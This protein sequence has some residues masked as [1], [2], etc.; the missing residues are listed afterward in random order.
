MSV[1]TITAVDKSLAWVDCL[2]ANLILY[3]DYFNPKYSSIYEFGLIAVQTILKAGLP[4][5][6]L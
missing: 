2:L 4:N 1:G 5:V 6:Q 3:E